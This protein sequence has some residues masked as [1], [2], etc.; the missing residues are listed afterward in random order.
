MVFKCW[1]KLSSSGSLQLQGTHLWHAADLPGLKYLHDAVIP[2]LPRA[3]G[4]AAAL[5]AC[6]SVHMEPFC[7]S[8]EDR[9]ALPG[10]VWAAQ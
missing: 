3:V 1:L 9:V 4:L 7:A 8:R 2:V 10:S 6:F 5:A